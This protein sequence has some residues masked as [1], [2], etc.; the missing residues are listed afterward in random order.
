MR[1]KNQIAVRDLLEQVPYFA[2]LSK[3]AMAGV[4]RAVRDRKIAPG[5]QILVEGEPCDGL[6]FV[7]SGQV[8]LVKTSTEGRD[9][10]LRVLGPGATFNDIAVFDG[11]PNSD[12]AIAVGETAVALVPKATVLALVD[13][14]PEVARAAL[15]LLSSRQ[16]S[17][18]R[19]IEDLALRDVTARVAR[20]LLG[21]VGRH[22]HIVEHADE[23]CS[24][25]THQEIATMVGS[26][27]EVVQRA[28]KQLERDGA[29]AVER[30]RI[31]VHD[32]GKLEGWAQIDM[33]D[34]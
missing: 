15:K 32:L 1:A 5:A 6:Y 17:F 13:R 7:V 12:S 23:A 34:A 18:G 30:S 27:R 24:H 14:H 20:L 19:V 9:H 11:G 26:V 22:E 3:D 8:R 25:I 28:L 33:N 29:I 2:G 10:V 4:A 21:C 31:K 16:R